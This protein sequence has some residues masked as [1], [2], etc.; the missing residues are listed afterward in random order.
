MNMVTALVLNKK[1]NF[2][3]IVFHYMK[4]NITSGSK[5]WIYPRFVQM[6]L[7]HAYPG[8]EKDQNNDLL[9][10]Y[11]MDNETLIVL[12]RYHKNYPES[13][14]KA[15]FFGFIKDANYKDPDPVDHLKWRNDKEMKEPSAA[16]EL[17][18]LA[19]FKETRNEWFLKEEKKKRSRKTTLKVQVE[20]G[21]SSQPKKKRQKKALKE[22]FEAEKAAKAAG[23]NVGD[24]EEESSSSSEEDID[25]IERLKR[26][27]DDIEKQK[28][29][30][31]KRR[32]EKEDE[33]YIPS[34]ECVQKVQT[35]P[36]EGRKKSNA[37]KRV[38]FP[39]V[40]ENIGLE[41]IG[42]FSFVNDE[43]VK[44]LQQKVDDVL[45]ENKKL[46]D[47]EK[48]LEKRVKTVEAENSSL[49]KRVKADQAGIDILKVRIAELEE[50][51]A[52]SDEQNEYFKLKNKELEATN[53]K[54]EHEM[55]MMNK[56]EEARARRQAVIE[57]E[58]KNK[59]KGV[60]IEGVSEVTERAIVVS[61]P[62]VD[63]EKTILD[64]CI[65]SSIS[66][67]VYSA[68][69]HDD[70][71]NDD[72][73]QG[74]SGIKLIEESNEEN[75]DDYLHDD[76]N[77]E[78]ENAQEEGEIR[79]TYTLDDIIKMTHIE[80]INFK[81]DFEEELNQFNIN[82]QPDYQYN[83]VNVDELR[84]GVEECIKNKSFDEMPKEERIEEKK[85]WF[86]K[87]T[88]R[89]FK[90]PLKYYKTDREVSLSD[91]ISW[92]YLPQVNAY[93]I[94]REFGVQYFEYIQDIMSLPWWDVEELPKVRT[95]TYPIRERDMPTWG[96]MKFE[97]FKDFKHWKPHQPKKVKRVDPVTGIEETI[98]QIKKPRVLKNISLP[99]MEQEF[100]K[101]FLCW[102]YS[103]MSTE[104]V[105]TYKVENEKG[106]NSENEWSSKW[107]KI[108]KEEALKAEKERQ[109]REKLKGKWMN[110]QAE[111]TLKAAK[112]NEK[113]KSLL[114]RKPKQREETFKSL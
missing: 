12:S 51:K 63:P 77:E 5:T 15:E 47:R 83:Q 106:I 4:E 8:L 61:E 57:A 109:D 90:R 80:D 86:R 92:G 19:D 37:R 10:L 7:D 84:R 48:K 52:R 22:S 69:S 2:S 20:E 100:H 54:K 79:H 24:N 49:L 41:D 70:D 65:I 23:E 78:P 102:V 44:K 42:D 43:L 72:D 30:K 67:D 91:I 114:K 99:K 104:V 11:H 95:L 28:Q 45:V 103:C 66:D 96:L 93:A 111:E 39:R 25:E 33:L 36:S 74:T 64:A 58:M 73:D 112:E 1:C 21:S 113:L 31:R 9:A 40:L 14:T 82:Q 27:R 59:G 26:I 32:E 29:L 89:K 85:K 98:L 17:E 50:E 3:R 53:A 55:Y 6:I 13:T 101:G 68:S 108:E 46:I 60:P 62:T 18:K 76:A 87:D 38:E 75:V 71:G 110:I 81:F 107:R 16:D 56:V 94:R 97:A 105:I 34:P 35:P 88:E